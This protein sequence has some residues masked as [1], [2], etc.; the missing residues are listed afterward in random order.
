ML[1][2]ISERQQIVSYFIKNSLLLGFQFSLYSMC[3]FYFCCFTLLDQESNLH[4]PREV[5]S[6]KTPVL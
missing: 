1:R 3:W 6:M 2:Q 4:P 5:G